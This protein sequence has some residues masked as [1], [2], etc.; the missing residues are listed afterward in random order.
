M[1]WTILLY[2]I[3]GLVYDVVI[4]L[5][6]LAVTDRRSAMAG[7]WSF[8]ITVVQVLI[9]YEI[10]PSKDFLAQLIAYAFGCGIGTYLTVKY[11]KQSQRLYADILALF[12]LQKVRKGSR[13]QTTRKTEGRDK[14]DIQRIDRSWPRMEKPSRRKDVERVREST[15]SVRA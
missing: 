8:L 10:I 7:L 14:T 15:P 2:F 13:L 3:V 11:N 9:L 6:Y 4:T 12:G 5:Y 1:I